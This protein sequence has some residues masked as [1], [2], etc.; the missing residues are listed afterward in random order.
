MWPWEVKREELN[1][2]ES[3]FFTGPHLFAALYRFYKTA[4][5]GAGILIGPNKP[6]YPE[7][8]LANFL[9][10]PSHV[11]ETILDLVWQN[12]EGFNKI[13]IHKGHPRL[14]VAL[15]FLFLIYAHH[16]GENFPVSKYGYGCWNGGPYNSKDARFVYG[17][18]DPSASVK[19]PDLP[20]E[21]PLRIQPIDF[22]KLCLNGRTT[23]VRS[24][25]D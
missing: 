12:G 8:F 10:L 19:I 6:I 17:P 13:I 20:D 2:L 25:R 3:W 18:F 15:R 24:I 1:N 22:A 16:K 23:Y 4:F 5:W 7:G 9:N 21:T 11:Q 14:R